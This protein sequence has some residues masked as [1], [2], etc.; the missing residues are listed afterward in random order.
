MLLLMGESEHWTISTLFTAMDELRGYRKATMCRIP[1]RICNN[2]SGEL[3]EHTK[4]R[5]WRFVKEDFE[6]NLE[7]SVLIIGERFQ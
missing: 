4:W 3:D 5:E 6:D 2:L 7:S 1:L